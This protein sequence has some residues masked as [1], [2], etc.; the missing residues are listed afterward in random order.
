[1]IYIKRLI[2]RWKVVKALLNSQE[3]FLITAYQ[4]NN[5]EPWRHA[6]KYDYYNNTDRELFYTI[7]SDYI[8]NKYK[9]NN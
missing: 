3:Y 9:I 2:K 1:M 6:I 4:D 8:K 7:I 5:F